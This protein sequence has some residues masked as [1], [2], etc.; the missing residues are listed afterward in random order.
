MFL[1]L[2]VKQAPGVPEAGPG[3]PLKLVINTCAFSALCTAS[4][5]ANVPWYGSQQMTCIMAAGG[6]GPAQP[7]LDDFQSQLMQQTR[8]QIKLKD[9]LW[10]SEFNINERQVRLP[11]TLRIV[12]ATA[13]CLPTCQLAVSPTGLDSGTQ[14]CMHAALYSTPASL[15]FEPPMAG[16]RLPCGIA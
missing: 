1:T 9:P 7:T 11:H 2:L 3:S 5:A 12:P 6:D 16:S 13:A 8:L 10:Q 4:I 15:S 14:G